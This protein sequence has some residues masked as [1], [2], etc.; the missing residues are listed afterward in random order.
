VFKDPPYA[1]PPDFVP[2]SSPS[3]TKNR[4]KDA[5]AIG[6]LDSV[7]FPYPSPLGS[8]RATPTSPPSSAS[9][10]FDEFISLELSSPAVEN[11][12]H[13]ATSSPLSTPTRAST[14]HQAFSPAES[15]PDPLNLLEPVSPQKRK[16]IPVP[17]S[18][19]T[20]KR[21]HSTEVTRKMTTSPLRR[22]LTSPDDGTSSVAVGKSSNAWAP[23][24][25]PQK[26]DYDDF[27]DDFKVQPAFLPADPSH[28]RKS[29]PS[30]GRLGVEDKAAL[31]ERLTDL[32]DDVFESDDSL[33][34]DT[35]DAPATPSQGQRAFFL[36]GSINS[37]H[38]LLTPSILRTLIKVFTQVQRVGIFNDF[39]NS[40]IDVDAGQV[41]RLLKIVERSVKAA[42]DTEVIPKEIVKSG[43]V[44]E[45][46]G[47]QKPAKGK[48]GG[49]NSAAAGDVEMED[50]S[51][52]H[53]PGKGARQ[54]PSTTRTPKSASPRSRSPAI[55][56]E[57]EKVGWTEESFLAFEENLK[58]VSNALL[59]CEACLVI[60]TSGRLP[61]QVRV[62]ALSWRGFPLSQSD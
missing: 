60:M 44:T 4:A 2:P 36:A 9:K 26:P 57:A 48:R 42:E 16:A 12:H 40:T 1:F 35:A 37:S 56:E 11:G 54:S 8:T 45:D 7:N 28:S 24:A 21:I 20:L 13:R 62:G 29:R 18:T 34:P 53:T 43:R 23:S 6:A 10:F 59:A 52:Q 39:N 14:S 5:F 46:G 15:S 47:K 58:L 27:E 25:S 3:K 51:Q 41:A 50:T 38:A 31:V 19:P 49:Q 61:K 22:E 32:L 17:H 55:D 30:A 33:V